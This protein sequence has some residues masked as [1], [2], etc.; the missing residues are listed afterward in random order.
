MVPHM[1]SFSRK[2]L[3][4]GA[5]GHLGQAV[6]TALAGPDA[7]ICLCYRK[8]MNKAQEMKTLLAPS[9]GGVDAIQADLS[10]QIGAQHAVSEALER[11][12]GLTTLVHMASEFQRSELGEVSEDAFRR[13]IDVGLSASFFL[14][15][16]AEAAMSDGGAM[17]FFSDTATRRPYGGYLPY[18]MAKAGVEAMVRGLARSLA[19]KTRVNA[20]APYAVS[21]PHDMSEEDWGDLINRTPMRKQTSPEEI[22]SLVRWLAFDAHTTTGQI[23]SVDGGRLLR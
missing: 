23:I 19:P 9:C 17:I 13:M 11:M 22:A 1:A 7:H 2:I 6:A 10:G 4:T 5:T 15:Q 16:A 18:C 3:L 20:V 21:K 14:A 8:S 12:G